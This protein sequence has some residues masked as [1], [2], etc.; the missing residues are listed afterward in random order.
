V[1]TINALT[2]LPL[3]TIVV[4]LPLQS[5]GTQD[6]SALHSHIVTEVTMGDRD[7]FKKNAIERKISR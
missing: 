6:A 4:P 3:L 2:H 5:H 7:F 1:V